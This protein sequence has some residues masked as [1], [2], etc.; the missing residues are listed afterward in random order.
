MATVLLVAYLLIVL[1]LIAVILVQRSEGGGLGMGGGGTGGLMSSRGSANILTR[2]TG[3]LAALF[4]AMAISLTI[5]NEVNRGSRSILDSATQGAATTPGTAGTTTPTSVLDALNKL[6]STDS[7]T[8]PV[9][10]SAAPAS[11]S[12]TTTTTP[13]TTTAPATTDSSQLPVPSSSNGTTTP[14]TTPAPA[15]S[16]TTTGN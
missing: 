10:G 5:L 9:P 12:G 7:G 15:T 4:F 16:G 6:Q 13:T 14:S 2:T 3:I 8:L 1:A 11:T